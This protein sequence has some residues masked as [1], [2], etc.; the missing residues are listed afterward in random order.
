[1]FSRLFPG[2]LISLYVVQTTEISVL[3]LGYLGF[4]C[5]YIYE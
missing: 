3:V 5:V 4:L 2:Y 1:M